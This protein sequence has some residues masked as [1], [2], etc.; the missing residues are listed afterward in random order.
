MVLCRGPNVALHTLNG[1]LILEQLV[2]VEGDELV[3]SCAFYE[4]TGN[5]NLERNLIFTGH[6]RGVVNVSQAI[7]LLLV[8]FVFPF[9]E[10][11]PTDSNAGLG[12][13]HPERPI[14]ARARQAAAS[15]G[16]RWLQPAY[17]DYVHSAAG[18]CRLHGR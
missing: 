11:R 15:Y 14:R 5:E 18:A 3:T 12:S 2:C 8:G 16:R 10:L 1:E 13:D 6:K 9:L 7:E 17:V 4:G